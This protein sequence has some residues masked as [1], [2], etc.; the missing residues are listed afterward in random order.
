[1]SKAYAERKT[2]RIEIDVVAILKAVMRR[3]VRDTTDT[4]NVHGRCVGGGGSD[5]AGDA[6]VGGHVHLH[7][8]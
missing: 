3:I 6:C 5:G 2:W 7:T 8:R 1:M 4:L